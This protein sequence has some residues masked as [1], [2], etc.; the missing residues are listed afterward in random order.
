MLGRAEIEA[1]SASRRR[2]LIAAKVAL[3][4]DGKIA[5]RS[6]H[7]QWISGSAARAQVM[8]DRRHF[9][10]V[11]VGARTALAD[12][13]RL[14]SRIPEAD[15]PEACPRR[16]LLDGRLRSL[17]AARSLNLY[18]DAHRAQTVLICSETAARAHRSALEALADQGVTLWE[19]PSDG[20]P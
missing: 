13:P 6:G 20:G 2:V 8:Q 14:T 7:S 18:T 10:A 11:M 15:P 9:D 3:T 16:L 17:E 5:T 12:N 4:L 19:L 1:F